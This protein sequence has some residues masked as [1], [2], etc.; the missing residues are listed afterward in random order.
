MAPEVIKQSSLSLAAD[1]W[2][3]GATVFEMLTGYP[4]FF[5]DRGNKWVIMH[6]IAAT[7][8]LPY[9][10]SELYSKAARDFVYSCLQRNPKD[11]PE[12]KDLLN[13]EF[14]RPQEVRERE[15]STQKKNSQ[16]PKNQSVSVQFC[17][18]KRT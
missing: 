4:P 5:E 2:S 11:R 18:K 12:A 7:D 16:L 9:L 15:A 13:S 8:Q 10:D 14:L 1:I 17:T 6:K 3:L